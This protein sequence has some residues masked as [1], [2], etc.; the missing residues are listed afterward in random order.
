[1]KRFFD[2][3]S[4]LMVFLFQVFDMIYLS[5]L[6]IVTSIPIITVGVS[7]TALYT[8]VHRC[9]QKGESHIWSTFW[10]AFREN[11]RRA[12]LVWLV[13]LAMLA[14]L[15]LDALVFR[16]MIVRGEWMG[17]LYW[18]I[19]VL[20]CVV[21][22]W[23]VYLSAYCARCHG[24]VRE[25][26]WISLLLMLLHPVQVLWVF[27]PILGGAVIGLSIP[28]LLVFLPAPVCWLGSITIEKVLR[29]HMQPEDLEK[30]SRDE[31]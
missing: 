14:L 15:T 7:S 28:G 13:A 18:V 31:K 19:L 29:V 2:L 23:V 9:I 20:I 26:L 24:G 10:T 17:N 5:I 4:P 12:T 25:T 21:V 27:L 8:A 16:N 30:E 11:W 22:T 1:M 3:E 6:W